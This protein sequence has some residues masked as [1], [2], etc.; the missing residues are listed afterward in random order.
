MLM[1]QC[2]DQ[3]PTARP[4]AADALAIFEA[5]SR[6]WV[7]PS[8]E[9]IAS[10]SLGHPTS[11]DPPMAEP[12]D[13]MSETGFGTVGGDTADSREVGH[14]PSRSNGREGITVI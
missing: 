1:E 14:S 10:L 13:T 2:W 12:T 6:G 5:S 9:A 7:S 3:V 8:P 4:R 11:Q